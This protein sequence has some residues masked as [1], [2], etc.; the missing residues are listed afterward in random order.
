MKYS[1]SLKLKL[2]IPIS[3][4]ITLVCVAIISVA[5][6]IASDIIYDKSMYALQKS[7]EAYSKSIYRKMSLYIN[8]ITNTSIKISQ[9]VG[10][11]NI[12]KELKYQLVN[13]DIIGIRIKTNNY[14]INAYE[15]NNKIIFSKENK[16]INKIKY[17]IEGFAI[18]DPYKTY[19]DE[20]IFTITYSIKKNK[21]HIGYIEIDILTQEFVNIAKTIKPFNSGY[22]IISNNNGY[23]VGHPQKHIVNRNVNEFYDV[24]NI[25]ENIQ[26]EN[27]FN[28]QMTSSQS[29]INSFYTFTPILFNYGIKS[30]SLGVV[31]DENV[32]FSEIKHLNI[33]GCIISFIGLVILLVIVT[34][35]F[36]HKILK[37]ILNLKSNIKDIATGDG[38]LRVRLPQ[39][40]SGDELDNLIHWFNIFFESLHTII[41]DIKIANDDLSNNFNEIIHLSNESQLELNKN[42]ENIQNIDTTSNSDDNNCK[43][44]LQSADESSGNISTIVS[45]IEEMSYTVNEIAENADCVKGMIDETIKKLN[46]NFTVVDSLD[47]SALDINTIIELISDI[48]DQ[49]NLLSLNAQ[50]ESARA[51]EAGKGFA[52]VANEIK[53]LSKQ[54]AN[55]TVDIKQKISHVQEQTSISKSGLSSVNT[56]MNKVNDVMNTVASS[57]E[58]QSI[59]SDEMSKNV[60]DVSGGIE[61]IFSNLKKMMVDINN[62]SNNITTIDEVN[63]SIS[64]DF[65]KL[66]QIIEKLDVNCISNFKNIISKFKV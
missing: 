36:D 47:Q 51:G 24:I 18:S 40:N 28:W 4:V 1:E 10:V 38:D 17:N 65:S 62:M 54:T 42:T 57:T 29:K 31:V 32:F 23:I 59:S 41:T 22:I 61:L 50:I 34:F 5:N 20:L 9:I 2:L 60:T 46:D 35:I 7:S 6:H 39:N 43:Q 19:A 11:S 52:V 58:E 30:W 12:K 21:K 37:P 8:Q 64:D 63:K 66:V 3:I 27:S 55:A 26:R 14:N 53:E 15:I 33:A 13:T 48:A 44:I 49:T 16:H 25:T 56:D 45:G